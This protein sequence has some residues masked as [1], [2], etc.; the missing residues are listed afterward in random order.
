M[1]NQIVVTGGAGFIGSHLTDALI[2]SGAS[3]TVIDNLSGGFRENI[4]PK[5][6]FVEM[7]IGSEEVGKVF[8]DLHPET[9][10]H[11]A[12]QMDVARSLREPLHDTHTNIT[13]TVNLLQQSV[14]HKVGRFIFASTAGAI[15][16]DP[17]SLP[18][19]EEHA[20]NPLSHYGLSKYTGE[21]YIKL[22][23]ELY[24]LPYVILRFSNVYGPRQTP[25]GEAGVCAILS[26]LMLRGESPILFGHGEP[27]RDYVFVSDVANACVLAQ[28][29]VAGET[30]NIC[31]GIETSVNTIYLQLREHT[32]FKGEPVLKELRKGE[33]L[34][35][36]ACPGRA[37]K[38]L[39]WR[40]RV[41]VR[42]GL[43]L[44]VQSLRR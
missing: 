4:N 9:V 20:P 14:E 10:Y 29:G 28:N 17:E 21:R 26:G 22:Y 30:L 11:L 19:T 32:G 18:A 35:V 3:V 23:N 2:E 43:E 39:S 41:D 42:Q 12:A 25:H 8:Q 1:S 15:Y 5:A 34:R 37:T 6:N 33:V 27:T 38:H 44:T 13:G 40:H 36:C 31:T 7:D 24:D 16:G